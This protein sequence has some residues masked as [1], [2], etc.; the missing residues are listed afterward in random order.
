LLIVKRSEV[1]AGDNEQL[2]EC[3]W[4][5]GEEDNLL[6]DYDQR[7]ACDTMFDNICGELTRELDEATE[8]RYGKAVDGV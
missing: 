7:E 5:G 8:A 4:E 3:M 2:I 6:Y 1:G